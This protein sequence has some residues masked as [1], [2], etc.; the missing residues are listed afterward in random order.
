M[1][2]NPFIEHA[3]QYDQWFDTER[4]ARLFRH[5]VDCLQAA[6]SGKTGD[7]LEVGVGSGRFAAAL[8]IGHGV[9]VSSP[10]ITMARERGINALVAPG[11]EMPY[12]DA[13]FDGA[14][15][16]CS[17]CFMGKPTEVIRECHRVIKSQGRLFIA[18]I[19]SDSPLGHYNADRG[20]NHYSF[21]SS[22]RFFTSREIIVMA[23]MCSFSFLFE[24][25]CDLPLPPDIG[26]GFPGQSKCFTVLSFQADR[27]EF[28]NEGRNNQMHAN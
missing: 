16:V 28:S 10:M 13:I 22:A 25:G 23:S 5:E 7:W 18:H 1:P 27:K 17:L 12:A 21:Y 4:G 8:G 2:D 15:I 24:S 6:I 3:T 11:E 14:V 26:E 19:P 9:D 20:K